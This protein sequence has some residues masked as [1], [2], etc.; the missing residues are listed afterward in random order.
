MEQTYRVSGPRAIHYAEGSAQPGEM[1]ETDFSAET[2][3]DHVEAGR[4]EIVPREY[5]VI[6]PFEVF[7]G[8]PGSTIYAA[9]LHEQEAALLGVHLERVDR[10]KGKEK[11]KAPADDGADKG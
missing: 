1:F 11:A 7:E 2:E 9:L 6:G 4:L 10:K 3:R 5:E 8:K